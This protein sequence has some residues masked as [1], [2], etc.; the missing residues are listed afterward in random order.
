VLPDVSPTGGIG[1][2]I[3]L[4]ERGSELAR[5]CAALES[6]ADG[7]PSVTV[8]TGEA[9]I[10]K[11]RLVREL[12]LT[13]Q[14]AD[15]V[16]LR[17]DCVQ[18]DGV[19]LPY[20][21]LAAALRDVPPRVMA[22]ALDRLPRQVRSEVLRSFPH[23]S[24]GDEPHEDSPRTDPFSQGRLY[25]SLFSLLRAV[26]DS[27]VVLLVIEDF[28]WVDASTRDFIVFLAKNLHRER[29]AVV[30][31]YR[32]DELRPE[33]PV[34][35]LLGELMRVPGVTCFELERLSRTAVAA[36]LEDMLDRLPA[37]GLV[38]AIYE[39]SGGNPF[40]AEMLAAA[41]GA[42]NVGQLP[43][44]LA[45]ALL[46]RFQ[47]LS[48]DAQRVLRFAA[49]IAKPFDSV[50]LG[51]VS[52]VPEPQLS[53][54]LREC[55][56]RHVL[57]DAAFSGGRREPYRAPSDLDEDAEKLAFRHD[58]LREAIYNDLL[59]G[60]R[61]RL[62]DAIARAMERTG[63]KA[64]LAF[65]WRAAGRT[66]EAL[67]ASIEAGLEAERAH[68]FGDALQQFDAA[69]KLLDKPGATGQELPL[70]RVEVL[71]HAGDMA[72]F[73]GDSTRACRL[74]DEA[75]S[76]FDHAADPGRAA[77]LFE[78]RGRCESYDDDAGLGS[79]AEALRLIPPDDRTDR[80]R[81]LS[82][83]G[84]ALTMLMRYDEALERCTAALDLALGAHAPPEEGYARMMLGVA[85]GFVGETDAGERELRAARQLAQDAGR[86]EELL[87]AH[88]YLAEV[89]R[90]QGRVSEALSVMT[91]GE[92]K[93]R[94]LGM[95]N[96]FGRYMG[97][98]AASDL[99]FVGRWDEAALRV[100]TTA[101]VDLEPW[102][103]LL[104]EQVAGQIALGQGRLESAETHLTDAKRLYDQGAPA[105][106]APDV[107][108]PLAELALWRNR[109][110][111]A[112]ELISHGLAALEGRADLLHAPML[113]AMGARVEAT[114]VEH[115]R[116][117]PP[118]DAERFCRQLDHLLETAGRGDPPPTAHAHQASCH[119]EAL[120][121]AGEPSHALWRSAAD[122]WRQL[123][124]PYPAAYASW[125]QA[126]SMLA[127]GGDRREAARVLGDA[128]AAA[129]RLGAGQLCGE[130]EAL[131]RAHRLNLEDAERP[132]PIAPSDPAADL[133]LTP[134]EAEVLTLLAQ[135]LT[136]RQI[137]RALFISEKTA[138][139]HVS[140]I[141]AKLDV[142]SRAAATAAVHE[143]G[144][145][146]PGGDRVT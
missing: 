66:T 22:R 45:D 95:Y 91:D 21:P 138:G 7:A 19:E 125:R 14:R 113:Y 2:E 77:S 9:G 29:V 13:A 1:P 81:V 8:V 85:L 15:L 67:V 73:T 28:H 140:H 119:G 25:E 90:L 76:A 24:V 84:F 135:G 132:A 11:S 47:D 89:L 26:S 37:P 56:E 46:S 110:A 146:S 12:G 111:L 23:V 17:G 18:F 109:P 93:A 131:A 107:Y 43:A 104:R 98:N 126:Q 61:V 114:A 118:S 38:D 136:N 79:Y 52:G 117:R 102:E 97:L 121:A 99:F 133:G 57:V 83:E 96:V 31:T 4:L 40:F 60:E 115:Q 129:Q 50:A 48:P 141:Y 32:S 16:V 55:R 87:R 34:R 20:G 127:A 86:A 62:H 39:R 144:L 78:R 116:P 59:A 42:T 128:H 74:Y 54:A 5:L 58:L 105:E 122:A 27:V 124:T 75:L 35:R 101:G 108:A 44:S 137:A 33:H 142:H 36:Q 70:D 120:R 103:A 80:A 49:A 10:G 68:A 69:R 63:A 53:A 71:R 123:G 72:K 130:I 134:R 92:E 100:E 94:E 143:A 3:R 51:A 64:E 145:L 88:L 112:R 65:H 30:V 106:F 41:G 6:A 139:V 82:E